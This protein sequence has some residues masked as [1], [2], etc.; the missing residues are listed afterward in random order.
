MEYVWNHANVFTG[1]GLWITHRFEQKY[2]T[3]YYLYGRSVSHKFSKWFFNVCTLQDWSTEGYQLLMV[4][5][6][7]S[8]QTPTAD[9]NDFESPLS[10]KTTM[11]VQMDFLKS[12][13]TV[14]P[15]MVRY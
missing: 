3:Q 15:C 2:S 8:I 7:L 12:V 9:D 6:I 11:L 10:A 5:E 4:R 1:L 13:L 14:N